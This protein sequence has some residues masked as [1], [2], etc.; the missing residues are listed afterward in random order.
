MNEPRKPHQAPDGKSALTLPPASGGRNRNLHDRKWVEWA[1]AAAALWGRNCRDPDPI[2]GAV[3]A[4]ALFRPL[5]WPASSGR[6]AQI[7]GVI[8]TCTATALS[9][10]RH[11]FP[12]GPA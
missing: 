9:G 12:S 6:L 7:Q 10:S 5:K 3:E 8:S 11:C 4:S 2:F 1:A